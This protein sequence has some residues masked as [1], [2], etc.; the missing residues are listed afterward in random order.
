MP[1][2]DTWGSPLPEQ[3]KP[4]RNATRGWTDTQ[5]SKESDS[6][7]GK[8]ALF[9]NLTPW[10]HSLFFIHTY[11]CYIFV[12]YMFLMIFYKGY[13]LEFPAYRKQQEMALL[14]SIPILQH[15]FFYFGHWGNHH[16]SQKDLCLFLCFATWLMWSL[17]Y[18]LFRQA[19]IMPLESRICFLNAVIVAV[20]GFCGVVNLLQT[21]FTQP[22]TG[23]SSVAVIMLIAVNI[24]CFLVSTFFLIF[25]EFMPPTEQQVTSMRLASVAPGQF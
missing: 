6:L 18:F 13:A 4:S 9:A 17:M 23:G 20:E 21:L 15:A 14:M 1:Q 25:L 19:Y 7:S 3:Q 10:V 12:F 16:G 8:K 24:I 5:A 22:R 2:T 11:F